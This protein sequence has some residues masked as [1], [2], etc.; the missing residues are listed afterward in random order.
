MYG[1]LIMLGLATEIAAE[2]DQVQ[3]NHIVIWS[4]LLS[5]RGDLV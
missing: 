4:A 3:I 2:I 1:L 5:V